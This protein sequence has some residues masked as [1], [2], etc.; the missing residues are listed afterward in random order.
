MD[1][2]TP[3]REMTIWPH[4][5]LQR[6]GF[7]VV[8]AIFAGAALVAS[9]MM[10]FAPGALRSGGLPILAT[11]PFFLLVLGG[12]VFALR[13]NDRDRARQYERLAIYKDRLRLDRMDARGRL[14]RWEA[15][16]GM[17]R[18]TTRE[19]PVRGLLLILRAGEAETGVG[20]FLSPAE[21]PALAEE[22]RDLLAEGRRRA[23]WRS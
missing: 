11:A 14:S 7:F 3:L 8:P 16:L 2:G 19:E 12:I 4:R 20:D 10:F 5:S 23:A 9:A 1:L 18:L 6:R 13:R 22:L 15:P 17:V 21:R